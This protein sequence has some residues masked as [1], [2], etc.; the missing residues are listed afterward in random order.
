[1]SKGLYSIHGWASE[2]GE[3]KTRGEKTKKEKEKKNPKK[4]KEKE[5]GILIIPGWEIDNP[6]KVVSTH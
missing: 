4:E 3:E 2:T 1:M 6:G 5:N